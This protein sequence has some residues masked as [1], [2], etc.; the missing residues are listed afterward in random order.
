MCESFRGYLEGWL[1]G[2]PQVCA[3]TDAGLCSSKSLFPNELEEEQSLFLCPT[4][5]NFND[6]SSLV[7]M[8][9]FCMFPIFTLSS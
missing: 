8:T 9:P 2:G 1:P 4:I 6:F 7:K 5:Y 3:G